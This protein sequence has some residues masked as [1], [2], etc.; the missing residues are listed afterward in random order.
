MKKVLTGQDYS[1][2]RLYGI[3]HETWVRCCPNYN[4]N[5]VTKY[6]FALPV[7]NSITGAHGL[8]VDTES[9]AEY[10]QNLLPIHAERL[11]EATVENGWLPEETEY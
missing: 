11:V 4:P 6:A 3:N 9:E 10:L 1:L 7:Q 5:N 2:E 8:I